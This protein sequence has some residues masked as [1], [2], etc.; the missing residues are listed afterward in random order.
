MKKIPSGSK[1]FS[2]F[3]FCIL[4]AITQLHLISKDFSSTVQ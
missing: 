2:L 1:L 4:N 3:S